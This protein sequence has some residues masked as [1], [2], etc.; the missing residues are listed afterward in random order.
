MSRDVFINATGTFFPN[1]AV[2]NDNVERVLGQLGDRPSRSK[3]IVLASNNIQTRHYAID[4]TTRQPSHSNSQITAE[5]VRTLLQKNPDLS[6][7]DV[8]LLCCGTSAGDLLVPAH[9][10]M[11]Q[12]E[13]KDFCGEVI[14]TT[15]VCCSSMAAL[16]VAYLSVKAGE[17]QTALV[18]GS[19][20]SSQFMRAEFLQSESEAQVSDLEKNP[21]LAFEADFLRWMLSDGAGA[22]YLSDCA[23]PGKINLRINWIEGRSY[24]NEQP[25]CM[26]AGGYQEPGG[27]VTSWKNLRLNSDKEKSKYVMNFR[28]DIR[29]LRDLIPRYTVER[30]LAD[31]KK[32]RGLHPGDYTWFLPHYSS[33]FF[34]PTLLAALSKVDFQIPEVRWFTSLYTKGNIG[35]AS[36][37]A[38]LDDLLSQQTLSPGE[39]ILCYIPESARFS[40]YYVELEVV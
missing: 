4:P 6:L 3:R 5:A 22:F 12:G 36:I 1:P 26:F 29:L 8:Q 40:V 13:L 27:G 15:G 28:Q 23:L 34:R 35:S 10:Q 16:K 19:E 21:L 20:T 18:T 32:K 31:I 11:V 24:A 17:T 30:P 25:V 37:F 33:H 38:F 14:S 39:K 2:D 9:G 7:A